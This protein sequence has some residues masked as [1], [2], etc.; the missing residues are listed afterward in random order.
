MFKQL[1][2][3]FIALMIVGL[4]M[5]RFMPTP[6]MAVTS[7]IIPVTRLTQQFAMNIKNA[8]TSVLEQRDLRDR[9]NENHAELQ[10]LRNEVRQLR[11]EVA[12][13]QRAEAVRKTV[14]PGIFTTAEITAIDPS[15]LLSRL[16]I[17]M[18]GDQGVQRNMPVTVPTGLVGQVMEVSRT[19]AWV[20]TLVDPE[21]NVGIAI[22][23]KAG[24]GIAVGAP[25]DRLRAEFPRNVDVKVGDQ[26]VT[27][28]LGGVY[29]ANVRVGI[30]DSVL[31]L[32]A[33]ATKRVAFIKPDVDV[34]NLEEV[35]LL[36]A[37]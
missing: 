18:G 19:E 35:I 36:R 15:P 4:V 7:G 11:L 13:L 28:S 10:S 23:G 25:P 30:V 14:S 22:Q 8:V 3:I 33:N 26:I 6:P 21:S 16:R 29:P 9:Y 17:N 27:A 31:P 12:R 24:R 5:T 1:T 37:L 32:G 20:I 34:S 2:L